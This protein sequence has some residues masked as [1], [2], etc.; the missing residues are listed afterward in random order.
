MSRIRPAY[1]AIAYISLTVLVAASASPSARQSRPAQRI[2]EEYT[3]LIREHSTEKRV[4]TEFVDHLPASDTV[5]TPLKFLG[6]VPGTPGKMT[7][8]ADIVRYLE[9]L[10]KAS[11]RVTMWKIGKSDEGRDMVSVAIADEATIKSLDKYKGITSQLTDPRK[12]SAEQARQLVATGKPIY[13]AMGSIH[14]PETGSPEMLMEL[15]Y[16]VAVGESKFI[17]EIRNNIIFVFTPATEVDGREKAV[18]NFKLSQAQPNT[19][20]PGLIYWGKYVQHDNNRDAIGQGL[21]L[22]QVMMKTF[23]DWHPTVW[24]DLHES[25]TLLYTSTGTGPY[26]PIVDAIQVD[27]WWLLAKTEVMELTKRGVPG[28]W[29]YNFYDGWIPNY[30]FWIGNT[31]NSIGRFYETQSYRGT[32]YTLGAAQSR[33]WYRPNPTPAGVQWGP[34]SNVNMQQSALLVAMNHVAKNKETYLDN[35]YI[36]NRRAIERG[37]AG[38]DVPNAYVIPAAQHTAQHAADLVNL[39]R[40]QGGEVHRAAAAFTAGGAQI[41][42]GDYVLRMDQPYSPMIETIMGTQWYPADNPRPYDDL[43]WTFPY[44]RNVRFHKV[45][46]KAIL[47][48]PMTLLTSD[49]KPKNGIVASGADTAG[50]TVLINHTT[51]NNLATFR[52]AHPGVKMLAA[53]REFEAAGRTFVAGSF[54]IPNVDPASLKASLERLGLEGVVVGA[55]PS[56]ASHDLDV[57]RVGYIH[58]WTST[59]DEGWVRLAFD[60]YKIPY[61]YF[62][63]NTIRAGANLKAKYDVIIFPHTSGTATSIVEGG[64]VTGSAAR[65]YKKSEATPNLGTVDATDDMRGGLTRDGLRELE[66]FVSEGGVLITEG[67][68]S[69]IFPE[70]RLTSGITVETPAGLWAPGSVMKANFMDRTSP[71]A[72]GYNQSSIG[73]YFRSSPVLRVGGATNQFGGRGGGPELGQP[74][75]QPNAAPP[76]LTTLE[77]GAGP[78]GAAAPGGGRQGG[79]RQ[80]GGGPAFGTTGPGMPRVILSFPN[81]ANDLLLSGGLVGGEALTGRAVLVDAPLGKG[82]VVMF[83]TRPYWRWQTH[84]LFFLGFNAI[85]NWNDLDAK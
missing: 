46:D 4:M 39:V 66:K 8:H 18:D 26:N 71:L 68:T 45:T 36:K 72:Y 22:T 31:H 40:A 61:A 13:Y 82:H 84:G 62:A 35:Y 23:L 5:P 16:R 27:E 7:Y 59:Q 76:R 20:Q 32:N 17:Q 25:V 67:V 19:P 1:A 63:D 57:P 42:A 79:G 81:E 11:D 29:T 2:D 49:A 51:S 83:A 73:V 15:A 55:A 48:Q 47:T 69:T 14:T 65:P 34:R 78:A 50:R 41:A 30:L 9:A 44:L 70:Y 53:E 75:M 74:N 10:D 28:V 37:Q 12:T 43:G 54:I 56:V 58:T 21:Q 77:G 6:Y 33:E 85:L 80:G 24:H 38:T 52:F 60:H 3:K 64:G